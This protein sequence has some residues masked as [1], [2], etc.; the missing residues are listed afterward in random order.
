M[1]EQNRL[2]NR[3]FNGHGEIALTGE[4]FANCNAFNIINGTTDLYTA[5]A[6]KRAAIYNGLLY[7]T[8]GVSVTAQYKV[9]ISGVYYNLSTIATITTLSNSGSPFYGIVLEP[10][11]SIAVTTNNT[12]INVTLN[13]VEF[14]ATCA[15]FSKKMQLSNGNNTLYTCPS[16]TTAWLLTQYLGTYLFGNGETNIFI[17]NFSGSTATYN[18]YVVPS[19]GSVGTTNQFFNGS[20]TTNTNAIHQVP[21]RAV[22]AAGD[23]FVTNTNIAA[24][25]QFAWINVMEIS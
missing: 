25:G 22:L 2:N 24:T 5:P 16:N 7:N 6:G 11:E 17:T 4:K 23:F 13:I 21:I 18:H 15:F 12:G 9:K 14:D 10:G 3:I 1:A 19:G 20:P 8:N